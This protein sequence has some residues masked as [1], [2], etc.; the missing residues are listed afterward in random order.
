MR[1][2]SRFPVRA[3]VLLSFLP[4]RGTPL[5][6]AGTAPADHALQ[7]AQLALAEVAAPVLLGCMRPRGRWQLE[8]ESIKAGVAGVAMPSARTVEWAEESGLHIEWRREC[9]AL[10]R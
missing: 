3:L 9:C 10:H 4:A 2:V 1:L 6:G 8:V 7:I 5:A